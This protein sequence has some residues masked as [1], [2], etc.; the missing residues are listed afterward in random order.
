MGIAQ[1]YLI[2]ALVFGSLVEG[3][4]IEIGNVKTG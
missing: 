4:I 2:A 1:V 3:P